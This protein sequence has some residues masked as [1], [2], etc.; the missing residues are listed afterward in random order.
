MSLKIKPLTALAFALSALGLAQ[1]GRLAFDAT[2]A[3]AAG[4]AP[5]AE[6]SKA[7]AKGEGPAGPPPKAEAA[8]PKEGPP[9]CIPV[10]LAKEAGISAAE[11]RLLQSLQERRQTLDARERD[12][13]TR[14]NVI[15]TADQR[16]QERLTALKQVEANIEKLLGQVDD[17]EAQRIAGLVAVYEKMKPKDAARVWEGL[18]N[19]VLLKIAQ[20][21]K[22]P[23]LSLILAK[24]NPVRAREITTRLAEIDEPDM[25]PLT[26]AAAASPPAAT[27]APQGSPAAAKGPSAP[28][29]PAASGQQ[30]ANAA[31]AAAPPAGAQENSGQGAGPTPPTAPQA[32]SPTAPKAPE[33]KARAASGQAPADPAPKARAD[34][35]GA[36]KAP[37]KG[38]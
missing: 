23:S 19:A 36:A 38:G 22:S 18:D 21:M 24:M 25:S 14:E 17:L 13:V 15:G 7:E 3:L 1:V 34:A 31:P 30:A 33:A 26:N 8:A 4:E 28:K 29:A 27:P 20:R 5:K 16:V 6:A 37:A 2:S 35:G 32:R 10:D 9:M 11:F 12:I